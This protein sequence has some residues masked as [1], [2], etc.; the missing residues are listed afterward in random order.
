M[1]MKPKFSVNDFRIKGIKNTCLIDEKLSRAIIGILLG[2]LAWDDHK[3]SKIS[4]SHLNM[5]PSCYK[6]V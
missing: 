4:H 1:I 3:K 5:L 6:S 2:K